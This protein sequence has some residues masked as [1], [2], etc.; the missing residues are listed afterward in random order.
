M[1]VKYLSR[2]V[3]QSI[4]IIMALLI[5]SCAN[6]QSP[7]ESNDNQT[8]SSVNISNQQGEVL[9]LVANGEDFIRQGFVSKDGWQ[10]NFNHAYITVA[11]VTAYQT[12]PPFNAENEEELAVNES[13][14]LVSTPTTI[15]LAEGD[16]NASPITVN[17]V[18][19]KEGFYNAI[20]WKVVN[21]SENTG[22]IILDGKALKQ[23]ETINFVLNFP[24][25]LDY[26]CG[27]FVG[28]ERKGIVT[29]NQ[30]AEIEITFHFDHIFGDAEISPDEEL[31]I[32]ALGFKPLAV[33]ASN[34][35]L[36]T[37]LDE[38][39][40]NLSPEDYQ[41]LEVSL[42]SLGHVGEGHCRNN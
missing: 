39:K 35:Q 41:K 21:N 6:N 33:L 4:T 36:K 23:G 34:G 3:F 5:S 16:E 27:E 20:A 40:Q 31:N 28:D 25:V 13:V 9:T 17:Q 7:Q 19:A 24:I 2:I 22:S 30:S 26:A 14:N 1:S 29:E 42:Q 11:D 10:I 38:L 8:S 15:D 18:P 12:S 37:N 32:K